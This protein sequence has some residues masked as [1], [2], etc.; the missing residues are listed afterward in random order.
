MIFLSWKIFNL[1][2]TLNEHVHAVE[3][4]KAKRQQM[5]KDEHSGTQRQASFK[6]LFTGQSLDYLG[7]SK[8]NE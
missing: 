8:N 5:T 3:E 4:N 7:V 2:V 1:V 6:V